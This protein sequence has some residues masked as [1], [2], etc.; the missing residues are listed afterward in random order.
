MNVYWFYDIFLKVGNMVDIKAAPFS[1]SPFFHIPLDH[2]GLTILVCVVNDVLNRDGGAGWLSGSNPALY[3][4]L[5]N[6]D[7]QKAVSVPSFVSM[8][9]DTY[10]C[11]ISHRSM[12]IFKAGH[13]YGFRKR[14]IG[15]STVHHLNLCQI[16]GG[17]FHPWWHG[18]AALSSPSKKV[19][20]LYLLTD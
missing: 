5:G 11:F 20:G 13:N 3:N 10:T 9:W 6:E 8:E 16:G 17:M 1:T 7:A 4:L 18:G 14:R 2:G 15:K 19:L 12:I